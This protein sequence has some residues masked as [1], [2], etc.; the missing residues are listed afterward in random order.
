MR[1][2]L[3][4]AVPMSGTFY[5]QNLERACLAETWHMDRSMIQLLWRQGIAIT[6]GPGVRPL[7]DLA[8]DRFLSTEDEQYHA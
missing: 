2:I 8:V 3:G 4:P 1:D 5:S 6:G 7:L